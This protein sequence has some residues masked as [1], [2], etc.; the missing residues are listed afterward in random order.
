MGWT[1]NS[2]A[3]S[4]P[5]K[6]RPILKI[7]MMRQ[8]RKTIF[9]VLLASIA[10]CSNAQLTDND[11]QAIAAE[12]AAALENYHSVF[13][14]GSAIEM[15]DEIYAVPL[16]SV[17]ASGNTTAWNTREE[18]VNMLAS[19]L[20]NLRQ[21]GWHRSAMPSPQ[22]CVL[23]RDAGFASGQFIRYREDGT[24]ISRSGMAYIFQKKEDG[25]RMTTFLAH[26]ADLQLSC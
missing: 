10:T 5:D 24:E 17:G 12:I 8:L 21:Q 20:T 14:T 4:W 25:W 18:V 15:A 7:Q 19:L 16:L 6:P 26:D 9:A 3:A 1:A 2:N 23:G 13:S 11:R 22:I